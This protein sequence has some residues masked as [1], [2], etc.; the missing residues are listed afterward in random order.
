MA[1]L[2][3]AIALSA[4]I[5]AALLLSSCRAL[6]PALHQPRTEASSRTEP[7]TPPRNDSASSTERHRLLPLRAYLDELSQRQ[8][9]IESRLDTIARDIGHL[10][11][12][13]EE[14]ARRTGALQ[15]K[16]QRPAE[17]TIVA[18]SASSPTAVHDRPSPLPPLRSNPGVILPDNAS[19]L[20][21]GN[22][23]PPPKSP[24][25]KV[26]TSRITK[27]PNGAPASTQQDVPPA[28]NLRRASS[29]GTPVEQK[30]LLD[31]AIVALRAGRHADAIAQ[32]SKLLE[33]DPPRKGEYY[34]W[35]AVAYYQ[36]QQRD[37]AHRDAE[38]AW[39]LLRSSNSPRRPDVLY[40]LAVLSAEQ[41]ERDRARQHLQSLIES[42][43]SSDA[44]ILARRKLQQMAVK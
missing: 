32:L 11:H 31:S 24:P 2:S 42:F 1:R 13:Y 4:G 44:A 15:T 41:G 38:A 19:A 21:S 36:M 17:D 20:T 25:R 5:V 29:L 26:R 14:L 8:A 27:I 6:R 30:L 3:S 28:R 16:T 22:N 33:H 40:L 35:R 37:R 9:A 18:G 34:Y 39:Q 12:S 23:S 43:P 7:P 10:R